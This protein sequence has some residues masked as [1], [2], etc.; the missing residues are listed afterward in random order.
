MNTEKQLTYRNKSS[1][2]QI[3]IDVGVIEAGKTI[4]VDEP[5]YNPNFELVDEKS[6]PH[7]KSEERRIE[8][9]NSDKEQ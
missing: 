3:L 9:S 8:T 5:I 1:V 6:A 2:T 4:T 7:S